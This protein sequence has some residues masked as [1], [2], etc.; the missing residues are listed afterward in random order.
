ME[1]LDRYLEAVKKHLPWERRNDL[2]AEL[3]ANLEAQLE[4]KESALGRPLNSEEAAAW[5]RQLGAPRQL[6]ARYWPQRYLIGPSLYPTYTLVLRLVFFWLLV[7]L[8]AGHAVQ[9]I[10]NGLNA[11]ALAGA[12]ASIAVA[13]ALNV[14]VVTLIFAGIEIANRNLSGGTREHGADFEWEP[15]ALPC[16][17][18]HSGCRNKPRSLA[19]AVTQV[20]FGFLFLIWLLLIPHY[21]FL[22]LG[23]GAA[24]LLVSPFELAPI[25]TVFYWWIVALT[26][27][28][29]LWNCFALI[30]KSWSSSRTAKKIVKGLLGLVPLA[31]L[32]T[33][34]N[35]L[36]V[37]LR[38]SAADSQKY[39]ATLK[40]INQGIY[41]ALVVICVAAIMGLAVEIGRAI[42][43]AR[44]ERAA[45][46][47]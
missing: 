39:G 1:L 25:W 15:G 30:R 20:V 13:L 17:K 47:R 43:T 38:N 27:L 2:V 10:V 4:D 35:H 44:R 41:V 6:A 22:L 46:L 19:H 7:L 36:W 21:P 16:M 31:L 3:R 33:V 12:V 24:Y 45:A 26:F 23:P 9:L 5:I 34:R 32:F 11:A 37:T 18:R 29:W 42:L 14:A 8:I 28:E 40:S